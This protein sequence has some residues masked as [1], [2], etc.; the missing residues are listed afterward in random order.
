MQRN[1]L[2]KTSD[3]RKQISLD[4]HDALV[5]PQNIIASGKPSSRISYSVGSDNRAEFSVA[6]TISS[7]PG[8]EFSANT[9]ARSG[10]GIDYS[11]ENDSRLKHEAE[12]SAEDESRTG[13]EAE[14]FTGDNPI[15]GHGAESSTDDSRLCPAA[16]YYQ[17]DD[18]RCK[19]QNFQREIRDGN[20]S[21]NDPLLDEPQQPLRNPGTADDSY[22]ENR[23]QEWSHSISKGDEPERNTEGEVA[24]ANPSENVELKDDS[25]EK[26]SENPEIQ[27]SVELKNK[28]S[29]GK[30]TFVLS[31]FTIMLTPLSY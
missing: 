9:S 13:P 17:I 25:D 11:T 3:K 20:I 6:G 27:E 16:E 29:T 10:P 24:T 28:R 4:D 23:S 2:R 1:Q 7:G 31:M 14:R 18:L 26:T 19:D 22:E 21:E 15:P 30:E 8:A 12:C 5:V